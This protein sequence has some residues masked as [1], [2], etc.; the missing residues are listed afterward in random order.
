MKNGGCASVVAKAYDLDEKKVSCQE[1]LTERKC[2]APF[3]LRLKPLFVLK[4]RL[5]RPSTI[6]HDCPTS[7][8]P[9]FSSSCTLVL[10][11]MHI[12]AS[13][14]V[15]SY[16]CIHWPAMA[17]RLAYGTFRQFRLCVCNISTTHVSVGTELI[18]VPHDVRNE[19]SGQILRMCLPFLPIHWISRDCHLSR[20]LYHTSYAHI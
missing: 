16:R 7:P 6:F 17:R 9:N 15:L 14:Q 19:S 13:C 3:K 2:E 4:R 18:T 1:E 10:L 5:N 11:P 8:F 12:L 20:L